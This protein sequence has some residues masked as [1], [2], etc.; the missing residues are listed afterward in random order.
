MAYQGKYES[1]NDLMADPNLDRSEKLELLE[2]WRNDKKDYMRAS[3]EGMEGDV[4]ANL[5][6]E[7]KKAIEQLQDSSAG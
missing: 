6:I 4:S 7:I 2:A 1:P 5:L 3:D